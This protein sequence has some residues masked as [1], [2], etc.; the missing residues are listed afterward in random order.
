MSVISTADRTASGDTSEEAAA[1]HTPAHI[2]PDTHTT[3]H[4]RSEVM[5]SLMGDDA[6]TAHITSSTVGIVKAAAGI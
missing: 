3:R 2:Q 6:D 5:H 1:M 4:M